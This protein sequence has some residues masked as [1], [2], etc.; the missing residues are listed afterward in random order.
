M[1]ISEIGVRRLK[2]LLGADEG[3]SSR[4]LAV[5]E[6]EIKAVLSRYFS[7]KNK[8]VKISFSKGFDGINV[9]IA[10]HAERVKDFKVL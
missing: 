4:E 10:A 2:N 1:K 5:V 3:L 7:L 8:D 9:S 6:K